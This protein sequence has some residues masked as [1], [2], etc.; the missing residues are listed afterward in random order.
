MKQDMSPLTGPENTPTGAVM[1][2]G[3]GISG[4][5][6][7]L[8]LAN[9]GIR[10]HLVEKSPAIGGKMAQL[11]KTFPTND[12]SMCIVSPKLV[13]VGRHK[14]IDLYTHSEVKSL[15]GEAGKFTAN[16]VRHSRY[17]DVTKCTGC[18]LCELVCPVTHISSFPPQPEPGEKKKKLR[19]KEK[20][21]IRGPGSPTPSSFKAWTFTVDEEKCSQCGLCHRACLHDAITWEKKNYARISQEKCTGC[22]ACFVACPEKFQAISVDNAPEME[23]SIGAAVHARSEALTQEFTGKDQKDC[24]RC[25]LCAITCQK[26]MQIGA[27]K[28]VKEGIEAGVDICQVCGACVS[29]C[30]VNFLDMSQVTNKEPRPLLDKFNENLAGRKPVNIHY[31]QAVP[32]VPVIDETSCVQ[33]NTGACG[34]CKTICGV[35]AIS[36][37]HQEIETEIEI[38]SVIFSPGFEP[39]NAELRGEFGYGQYKNVVTSIEF[40]RLLSASG[41]TSGTVSRPGDGAH[42]KKLPGSS[43][44]A[45]VI[46]PAT[47]I[48]VPRFAVCMQP[49][50]PL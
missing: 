1:V 16:I 45:P 47:E 50:K 18:G 22:G 4:M 5:Q 28:M 34:T 23:N 35:G 17:V 48:T 36:Y 42:P 14:N 24:I 38:G 32:R 11:D 27:L 30:P 39:F 10:V 25:G 26:V 33:L 31:P 29:I 7:A 44:L 6:S 2:I 46:T 19:A 13:E 3:G 37:D 15:D 49:R 20:R 21:I 40:E 9:S 12:C 8:D 43:A 41:P